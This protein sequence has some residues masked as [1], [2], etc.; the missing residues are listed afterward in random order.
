MAYIPRIASNFLFQYNSVMV[1]LWLVLGH[2][3]ALPANLPIVSLCSHAMPIVLSAIDKTNVY[4]ISGEFRMDL[5]ITLIT[6]NNFVCELGNKGRWK[7][8]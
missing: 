2:V 8:F 1:N 7:R 3:Y 5:T 6:N 4:F